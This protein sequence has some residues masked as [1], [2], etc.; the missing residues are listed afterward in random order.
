MKLGFKLGQVGSMALLLAT[1]ATLPTM[2]AVLWVEPVMAQTA[3]ARKAEATQLLQQGI[4][5]YQTSQ[6]E[7]ALQP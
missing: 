5:L 4:Q 2:P 1:A 6:F 7:A 3:D